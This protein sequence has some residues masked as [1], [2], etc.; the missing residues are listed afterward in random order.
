[1]SDEI[2]RLKLELAEVE[3]ELDRVRQEYQE[4]EETNSELIL[5]HKTK[6]DTK[7]T[8]LI[9]EIKSTQETYE[10]EKK[11][12][13]DQML[14]QSEALNDL[15]RKALKEEESERKFLTQIDAELLAVANRARARS[16]SNSISVESDTLF[17]SMH[18]DLPLETSQ[19][20]HAIFKSRELIRS[21]L[22]K[23]KNPLK[24]I[25]PIPPIHTP[26]FDLPDISKSLTDSYRDTSLYSKILIN[27]E[28]LNSLS[29]SE[30]EAVVYSLINSG[31]GIEEKRD[32]QLEDLLNITD[33]NE[34]L[35]LS[36]G[37]FDDLSSIVEE[38]SVQDSVKKSMGLT[39]SLPDVKVND[40]DS[41]RVRNLCKDEFSSIG[42]ESG[43]DKQSGTYSDVEAKDTNELNNAIFEADSFSEEPSGKSLK[44]LN[45]NCKEFGKK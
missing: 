29:M 14:I 45:R 34:K 9:K 26:L 7:H 25:P 44:E 16:N 3:S 8:R 5:T 42:S 28:L 18:E 40:L 24:S 11:L 33:A 32:V 30:R 4:K 1:M 20:L 17:D 38:E 21:L 27:D 37:R 23:T 43:R 31:T 10:R 19:I 15:K 6:W 22:E 41:L 36:S 2:E 13:Q 12:W 35:V 39:F